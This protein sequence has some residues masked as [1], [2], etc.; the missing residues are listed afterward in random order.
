MNPKLLLSL[1]L[2]SI[3]TWGSLQGED[4]MENDLGGF[5]T[6]MFSEID[7]EEIPVVVQKESDLSLSGD[8]AFKTSIAYLKHEVDRV[9]Y[10]GI[11]Q[12]QTS[13]FLQLDY[14]ISDD[15]KLRMSGDMFYD[16]IYDLNSKNYNQDVLDT[17]QTQVMLTDAYIQGRITNDLDLKIGHQI[18]VWGKSDS[19]RIT[20]VINPIDNRQAAITDIEDLRLSVA[21]IKADYYFDRWN[22][23]AMI[24]GENRVM[25]EPAPRGEFFPVDALFTPAPNPFIELITPKNSLDN[26]QYAL[27]LNGVFSGWDLSFYG[28]NVLDQKWHINPTTQKREVS[29]INML[30]LAINIAKGSWLLKSEIA[31]L[32]GVKYNSTTDEKNRLDFLVGFD[33]MGIKD[34]VLSLE[35]ANRHI[36]DYENQMSEVVMKPDYTDKDEIQ[37]ALRA[38]RSFE[39]D[40]INASALLSMF[41]SSWQ[42]GGFARV[43]VEVDLMDAVSAN[44]GVVDY[45]GGDKPLLDAIEKNDR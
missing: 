1:S 14:K 35:I 4:S 30:G 2:L 5:D 27:A 41:G 17:Y 23:S 12:A 19:I 11:N 26:M 28:A 33:Y 9:Q 36:F 45:I 7:I 44:V 15:W 16:A 37:T 25:L 21:M 10:S 40:S 24:I 42:N 38:T 32:N 39:N 22:L 34:T 20:D 18:V 3:L 29:K 6:E 8:I 43:W 13:L 31:F